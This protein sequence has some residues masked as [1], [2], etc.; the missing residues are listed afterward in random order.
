MALETVDLYR[1][2]LVTAG[3]EMFF[4]IYTCDLAFI[5]GFDVAV[6]TRCEATGFVTDTF[7][8]RLIPLMQ[9][10]V[11]VVLSHLICRFDAFQTFV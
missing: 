10:V 9:D 11:H 6:D 3:T 5:V 8:H 1:R 7:M 2:I 4:T